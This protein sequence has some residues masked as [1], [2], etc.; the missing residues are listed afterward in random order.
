MYTK[1][2]VILSILAGAMLSEAA[3]TT[4][5]NKRPS[6]PQTS[7]RRKTQTLPLKDGPPPPPK[8]GSPPPPKDL[9]A[10]PKPTRCKILKPTSKGG[11][12]RRTNTIT[13]VDEDFV[14]QEV[15]RIYV[16]GLKDPNAPQPPKPSPDK[17][18][19]KGG[20]G[21]PAPPGFKWYH[22]GSEDG[23][24]DPDYDYIECDF[25]S[26][27]PSI[28]PMPSQKPSPSPS[29]SPT[30]SMKPTATS[31]PS[32][33]PSM[34]FS[35]GCDS[36]YYIP[37][38]SVVVY[39][40]GEGRLE[41]RE[42]AGK[43]WYQL[44][45]NPLGQQNEGQLLEEID[46]KLTNLLRDELI[47]CGKTKKSSD[48][49]FTFEFTPGQ[50]RL[51]ETYNSEF[52]VD[53]I[54]LNKVDTEVTSY[55]CSKDTTNNMGNGAIC[56][57]FEGDFTTYMRKIGDDSF[58]HS[59]EAVWGHVLLK[60]QK[61]FQDG[62]TDDIYGA[63]KIIFGGAEEKSEAPDRFVSGANKEVF[64]K[65]GTVSATGGIVIA[66]GSML[67]L[68]VIF[69]ATRK[70]EHY[71]VKRVEQVFED[72]ESLFGKSV[73]NGTDLMSNGSGAW[74]KERG[75]HVMGEDDSVFSEMDGDDIIADIR[76]AERSRLY[77]MGSRGKLGPQENDLGATGDAL[78]VHSCT[79][80]TC[81]I[82]TGSGSPTFVTSNILSPI[83]E[84]PT[85]MSYS[86][87]GYDNTI[88]VDMAERDYQ[89]SDT[90]EM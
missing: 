28:S 14:E 71:R 75:A 79:S 16:D 67:V 41:D 80:A 24:P 88:D 29:S 38:N 20:K 27:T 57:V 53:G 55:A 37:A 73:A 34:A 82:C 50:R 74:R 36:D 26:V 35:P 9:L 3:K 15:Q 47:W 31:K 87:Q 51:M 84:V 40:P 4:S 83:E 46:N 19:S 78:N 60:I 61:V 90:I 62:F 69:A 22:F 85:P 7:T 21:T 89:V 25:P 70:R 12:R 68:L 10:E 23:K 17:M 59:N 65:L 8:D 13:Y 54:S 77:G 52:I 76:M 11:V 63:D 5:T 44:V 6:R 32:D 45:I 81:P 58:R 66:V 18:P 56:K 43:Y 2:I 72:D 64:E 86:S 49:P 30:L 39:G 1:S 42:T 48:S 33:A